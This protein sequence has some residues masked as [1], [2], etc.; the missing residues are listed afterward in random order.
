[1]I[2]DNIDPCATS[3]MPTI[4]DDSYLYICPNDL[5]TVDPYEQRGFHNKK[6]ISIYPFDI[7]MPW[8]FK[9]DEPWKAPIHYQPAPKKLIFKSIHTI[10]NKITIKQPVSRSGFRRGQRNE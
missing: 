9:F 2:F 7:D 3:T 5:Y 1:M 8:I 6:N 10:K 4:C